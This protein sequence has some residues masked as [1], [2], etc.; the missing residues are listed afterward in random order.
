M[1]NSV[2]D[3]FLDDGVV[4]IIL[5]FVIFKNDEMFLMRDGSFIL[6]SDWYL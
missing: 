3:F 4:G 5:F 1:I 2:I 6:N